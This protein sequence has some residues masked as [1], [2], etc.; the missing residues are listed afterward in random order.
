MSDSTELT[1]AVEAAEAACGAEVVVVGYRRADGYGDVVFRAA[2]LATIAA[3]AA[4]LFLPVEIEHDFAFPLI[5]GVTVVVL[6]LLRW[7][8]MLALL[9]SKARQQRAVDLVVGHTFLRRG[10]HKTGKRIGLLVVWFDLE[11]TVRVVFDSGLE[12]LVPAHVRTQLTSTLHQQLQQPAQRAA[13]IAAIGAAL[14]PF[15]PH[16]STSGDEL[17]NTVDDALADVAG[18]A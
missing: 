14:A 9:T 1:R 12:H 2:L 15:V 3:L 16:D 7:S 10:V 18:A 8:R 5:V 6:G 13:A 17:G 4:T 11:R